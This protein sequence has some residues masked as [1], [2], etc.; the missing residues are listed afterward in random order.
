MHARGDPLIPFALGREAAA[1][2]PQATFLPYEAAGAGV[3]RQADAIIPEIRRFL[4]L[5]ANDIAPKQASPISGVHTILF[6]DVEGSTAL[7]HA[8]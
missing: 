7:T 1:R 6:T 2:L 3:W 8:G 5:K 4:G